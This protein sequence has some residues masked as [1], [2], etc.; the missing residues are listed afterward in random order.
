MKRH[1]INGR[2]TC[3]SIGKMNETYQKKKRTRN[4]KATVTEYV[5]WLF[6]KD[7]PSRPTGCCCSESLYKRM[8]HPFNRN[9]I[10]WQHAHTKK[11]ILTLSEPSNKKCHLVIC[12]I[13]KQFAFRKCSTGENVRYISFT[14]QITATVINHQLLLLHCRSIITTDAPVTLWA[15][16]A[17]NN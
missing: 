4:K 7:L 12:R 9:R 2:E 11:I 6:R 17:L 14:E 16:R 13:K 10:R 8:Y 3:K 15:V 1:V 5:H